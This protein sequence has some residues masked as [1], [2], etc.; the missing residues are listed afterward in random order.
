MKQ[1]NGGVGMQWPQQV[2][3][4]RKTLKLI[5]NEEKQ[6]DK[7]VKLVHNIL[8]INCIEYKAEQEQ[9]TNISDGHKY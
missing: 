1:Y 7:T 9:E 8:S 2:R 5:I 3:E 4:A 6:N